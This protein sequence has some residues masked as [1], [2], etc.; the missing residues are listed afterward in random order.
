MATRWL[1]QLALFTQATHA[2]P[3]FTNG[4]IPANLTTACIDTLLTDVVQCPATAAN[5]INGFYYPAEVLEDAC[6]RQC[7]TALGRYEARV[8]TA[9]AGQTWAGYD[10][11][12]DAPLDMIPNLMRFNR[13]LACIQDSGR[14]CNVVAA[15]A[16]LKADPGRTYLEPA[17]EL[18]LT[19]V[20][21]PG[22]WDST[23]PSDVPSSGPCDL[24]FIKNLKMQAESP[25]Y[26]GPQLRSSSVYESKTS[27][28][29]VSDY[30][31]STSTLPWPMYV[32]WLDRIYCSSLTSW[33][34]QTLQIQHLHRALARS[35]LS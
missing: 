10:D 25:Y 31:L 4:T 5:F 35:I 2:L 6:N 18:L 32:C 15:A 26:Y 12:N 3:F 24:C 19:K 8:K 1:W 13:D 20:E 7:S 9:C 16:A 14:W 17:S 11:E 22:G 30:A 28:C 29:G 21:S 33:T 27:S 34:G 23:P